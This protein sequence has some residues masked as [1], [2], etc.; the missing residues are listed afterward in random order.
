MTKTQGTSLR[1]KI[2]W[3]ALFWLGIFTIMIGTG[4]A[5]AYVNNVVQGQAYLI[6]GFAVIILGIALMATGY[7][8]SL[9]R[10][11]IQKRQPF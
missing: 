6:L 5:T 9:G 7:L 1:V 2:L 11:R 3:R 8:I 4:L 10:I